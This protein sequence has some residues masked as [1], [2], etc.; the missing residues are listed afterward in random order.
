MRRPNAAGMGMPGSR[1]K[2]SGY[3]IDWI[4]VI[5]AAVVLL[6]AGCGRK[7]PPVAPQQRPLTAVADLKGELDQ[8]HAKLTWS[9]SPENW[10]TVS[11]VV[12]RAQQGLS[13][14]E[15]ADC[16]MVFQKA[17]SVPLPRALREEKCG[18]VFSQ[19]LAPGFRYTFS[20]RPIN[21]SGAQ[22]PDSNRV[23]IEW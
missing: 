18:L 16:P 10:G 12:L 9:H 23:V 14:P 4:W 1:V 15:C 3:F 22:G 21:A 6:L 5:C 19:N 11:Y 7:A 2:A 17:G 13:Q 20:V 8:G